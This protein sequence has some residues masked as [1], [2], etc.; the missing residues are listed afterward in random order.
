[1]QNDTVLTLLILEN[2]LGADSLVIGGT[3]IVVLTLLILENGLGGKSRWV[4][5][6]RRE[7]VL[8]LLILENGLGA[9]NLVNFLP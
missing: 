7:K 5:Q 6:K 2:G 3:P 4:I 8:T 9:G 1:M